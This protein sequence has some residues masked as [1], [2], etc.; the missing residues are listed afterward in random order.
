VL[1]PLAHLLAPFE[2]HSRLDCAAEWDTGSAERNGSQS[3]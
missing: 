3:T 2:F 1:A